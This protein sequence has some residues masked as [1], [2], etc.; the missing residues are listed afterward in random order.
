M[1][2]IELFRLI[3]TR[4]EIGLIT[5]DEERLQFISLAHSTGN[6]T[7]ALPDQTLLEWAIG[8]D[9]DVAIREVIKYCSYFHDIRVVVDEPDERHKALSV[10]KRVQ[11][12]HTS[13]LARLIHANKWN[14]AALFINAVADK[15]NVSADIKKCWEEIR[16]PYDACYRTYDDIVDRL[17]PLITDEATRKDVDKFIKKKISEQASHDSM[18]NLF[19]IC[20]YAPIAIITFITF[21]DII[22]R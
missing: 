10:K 14:M 6:F 13:L 5:D 16:Y 18:M 2:D 9:S 15:M 22:R 8:S 20:L 11:G 7:R 4:A 17:V 12:M 21:A 19:W 1:K 3:Q